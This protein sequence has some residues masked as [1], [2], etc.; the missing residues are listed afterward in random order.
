MASIELSQDTL[1]GFRI[2]ESRAVANV[3][4]AF[5]RP[6]YEYIY[7]RTFHRETA[8]DV[9]S[10]TFI[11]AIDRASTFDPQRGTLSA[12]LYRIA[13]NTLIDHIR[14]SRS[15]VS[16]EE[17]W[18][19][20][21]NRIALDDQT[22]VHIDMERLRNALEH[23]DPAHR[24]LVILRAWH[25]LSYDEISQI[26]GKSATAQKMSFSR[27]IARLRKELPAHSLALILS[28]PIFRS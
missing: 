18:I 20:P 6:I 8:E 16:L 12:W 15:T 14:A 19:L 28:F 5:V 7:F 4:D 24:E 25:G 21:D 13:R 23:L 2:G 26:T 10:E 22:D 1:Q 11:K 3:Y 27:V 9:T 17:A